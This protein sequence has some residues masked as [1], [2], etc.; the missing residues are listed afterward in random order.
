[1]GHLALLLQTLLFYSLSSIFVTTTPIPRPAFLASAGHGADGIVDVG[2]LATGAAGVSDDVKSMASVA[3]TAQRASEG[4]GA[5]EDV[6][7]TTQKLRNVGSSSKADE[8]SK[9]KEVN[10]KEVAL[11][12]ESEPKPKTAAEVREHA[13]KTEAAV[14]QRLEEIAKTHKGHHTLGFIRWTRA[15]SGVQT[16]YEKLTMMFQKMKM[17]R[18]QLRAN[19]HAHKAEVFAVAGDQ[20][21]VAHHLQE[22]NRLHKANALLRE[23]WAVKLGAVYNIEGGSWSRWY[24]LFRWFKG[25]RPKDLKKNFNDIPATSKKFYLMDEVKATKK[26]KQLEI[27]KLRAVTYSGL[28]N[29]YPKMIKVMNKIKNLYLKVQNL[30]SKGWK[31][32]N[33]K[34][35]FTNGSTKVIPKVPEA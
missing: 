9:F 4:L 19:Y 26:A 18:G 24:K 14:G 28:K 1:M 22:F 29:S 8:S 33:K 31:Y 30:I 2:R 7:L 11:K 23:R 20:A 15:E 16:P 34:F 21:K 17:A 27:S 6:A 35:D 32:L 12:T 10:V 13:A 25:Q 5:S 3:S